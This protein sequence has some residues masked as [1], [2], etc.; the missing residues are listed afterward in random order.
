MSNFILSEDRRFDITHLLVEELRLMAQ[1]LIDGS[2][3]LE[4]A[5][6]ELEAIV[7]QATL[8]MNGK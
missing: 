1:V 5:L 7:R 8:A 3:D 2:T 6:P 4:D